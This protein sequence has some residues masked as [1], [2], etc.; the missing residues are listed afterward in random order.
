M[1]GVGGEG[2]ATSLLASSYCAHL[3][4]I[5]GVW[6]RVKG[7]L[8]PRRFYNL[9][10][11]LEQAVLSALDLLGPRSFDVSLEVLGYAGIP[12][13]FEGKRRLGFGGTRTRSRK[14]GSFRFVKV[15][16]TFAGVPLEG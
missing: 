16:E 6:R 14:T 7:F 9:L 13:R 11:E 1:S 15:L 5:E 8:M 12:G 10:I 2:A 4:T 3:N